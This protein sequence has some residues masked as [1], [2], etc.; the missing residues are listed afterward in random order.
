[1]SGI[2]TNGGK[3]MAAK[4]DQLLTAIDQ[5]EHI[6]SQDS[7]NR[8]APWFFRME[9]ALAAVEQALRQHS[10]NLE[11][12]DGRVLDVDRPRIPS[13]GVVRRA[14]EL[15][16]GLHDLLKQTQALRARLQQATPAS[17]FPSHPEE[18]AG[19]LPVAPEAGALAD[20]GIL[21]QR[22]RSL[23]ENLRR[24]ENEEVDLILETVNTDVGAGD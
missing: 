9:Q 2:A 6:L 19:A 23:V 4:T 22:A 15:Q 21:C 12:P 8:E 20:F 17:G 7:T 5:L 14:G 13:P 3:A 24:Y 11:G 18:T 1:M 10:A 16:D